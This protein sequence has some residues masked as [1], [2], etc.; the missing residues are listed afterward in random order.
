MALQLDEVNLASL[1]RRLHLLTASQRMA[2]AG[3]MCLLLVVA[4]FLAFW[5]G[6][7]QILTA[8]QSEIQAHHERLNAQ[9]KLLL[10]QAEIEQ[11]LAQLEA[12]LPVL[13]QALPSDRELASLLDKMNA[14]IRSQGLNLTNFTPGESKSL[15]VMRQVP[16]A[17][18][19]SGDGSAMAKVPLHVA[20]LS[21]QVT[22]SKFEMAEQSSTGR[23]SM[24]GELHAF[25]QLEPTEVQG[26]QP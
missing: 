23:W 10:G 26:A 22:L 13:K 16:V 15:E 19:L 2:I 17:L 21:R 25:A 5:Q 12:R 4:F 24:T 20:G 18:S 9:S 14:M 1:S 11:E 3:C 6:S 8:N 7:L